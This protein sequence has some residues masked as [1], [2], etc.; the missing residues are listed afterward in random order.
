[1]GLIFILITDT[2]SVHM[3]YL[4]LVLLKL[5]SS[6]LKGINR[7]NSFLFS[8]NCD[9]LFYN[10]LYESLYYIFR[11]GGIMSHHDGAE[12]MLKKL[13]LK[14]FKMRVKGRGVISV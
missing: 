8:G 9:A 13:N 4:S 5:K 2:S 14:V 7:V 6:S 3:F 1:M 11:E 10:T 12:G